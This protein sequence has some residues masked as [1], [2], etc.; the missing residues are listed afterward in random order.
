M[1]KKLFA[2]AL[3]LLAVG[4]PAIAEEYRVRANRGLNLRADSSLQSRVVDTVRSGDI[5]PGR[6][7]IRAS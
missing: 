4:M 2:I 5:L 6:C 7:R 1:M 3:V